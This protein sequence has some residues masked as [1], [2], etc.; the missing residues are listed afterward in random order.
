MVT[1]R[2]EDRYVVFA[3]SMANHTFMLRPTHIASPNF[4]R[5]TVAVPTTSNHICMSRRAPAR[6]KSVNA[7]WDG[8]AE[9]QTCECAI[10]GANL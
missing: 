1:V 10:Y 5:C 8:T 7:E 3:L 4:H 6:C 9:Q 2:A